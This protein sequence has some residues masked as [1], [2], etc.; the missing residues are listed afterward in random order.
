M[1]AVAAT[2]LPSSFSS[3]AI[4]S[5]H[6][7]GRIYAVKNENKIPGKFIGQEI[8]NHNLEGTVVCMT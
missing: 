2:T 7:S 6:L 3:P 1:D 4:L 8:R 5:C